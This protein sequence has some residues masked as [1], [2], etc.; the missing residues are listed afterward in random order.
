MRPPGTKACDCSLI[1]CASWCLC[2]CTDLL[3]A[4]R[5]RGLKMRVMPKWTWLQRELQGSTEG[6]LL[7]SGLGAAAADSSRTLVHIWLPAAKRSACGRSHGCHALDLVANCTVNSRCR[8]AGQEGNTSADARYCM[9][10]WRLFP[11]WLPLRT[12]V[13]SFSL[14]Q[15]DLC[16]DRIHLQH[17]GEASLTVPYLL[18]TAH[19][20]EDGTAIFFNI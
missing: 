8:L 13:L 18:H 17:G 7:Q 6:H 2:C 15:L 11:A 3:S 5:Q 12:S 19:V 16:L 20:N 9:A 4:A 10:C 14:A 1:C